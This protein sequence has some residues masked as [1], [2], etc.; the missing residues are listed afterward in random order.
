MRFHKWGRLSYLSHLE[1]VRAQERMVRRAGLPFAVTCGFSPHMKIAFGPALGVG[2]AGFEEYIDIWLREYVDPDEALSRLQHAS[3]PDLMPEQV[4]YV[5]ERET[6]LVAALNIAHYR[7]TCGHG[8]V[9][10]AT[11]FQAALDEVVGRGSIEVERRKPSKKGALTKTL[12]LTHLVYRRPIC[13]QVD[14]GVCEIDLW[15][16]LENTGALRPEVLAEGAFHYIQCDNP[17]LNAD[18]GLIPL[19]GAIFNGSSFATALDAF[20]IQTRYLRSINAAFQP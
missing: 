9:A 7:V 19:P 1:V 4:R 18:T 3:V 8:P 12:D 17:W 20:L 15:T 13:R 16:R 14:E 10:D 5:H 6:S 11:V 2:T